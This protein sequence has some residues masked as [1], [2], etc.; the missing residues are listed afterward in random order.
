MSGRSAASV[1]GSVVL[2]TALCAATLTL[3]W[4]G[5]R[6]TQDAKLSATLLVERRAAEQLALLWAGVA[7]D[8]K[9][10]HATVLTPVTPAQLALEPPYD[11]ADAFARGF[12]RFP[13]PESFFAWKDS[14]SGDGRT[15]AFTR[16]DRPPHWYSPTGEG[17]AYPVEV[18][19]DPEALRPIVA[20]ARHAALHQPPFAVFETVVAG[21]TYQVVVNFFYNIDNQ[22][23]LSGLVG[24]TA[25]LDWVREF[26]FDELLRQLARIGG[27]P[28]DISLEI[29]DEA[30]RLVASNYANSSPPSVA[31]GAASAQR[32][33]QL[34]F[35]DRSLMT[36]LP[37]DAFPA[38]MWTARARVI[39]G[40]PVAAS[41]I[42]SDGAFGLMAAAAV[43]LVVALLVTVRGI[44][45]AAELAGMKSDFVSSVTHELKTPLAGIRL[46]ADTLVRGR[47]DSVEK[48]RDY[49]KLLSRE[50]KNLTRLID[51][52]LAYSRI[53]DVRHAYAFDPVDVTDL[54]TDTLAIFEAVLVDQKF[55]VEVD[56]PPELPPVRADRSAVV[57]ALSNVVDNALKY[58]NGTKVVG[59]RASVA[60]RYVAVSVTDKG[61]GIPKAEIQRVCEKFYRGREATG[62]GSGLGLAI[63]RQIVDAH[64]GFLRIESATGQGTRVELA[65]PQAAR[66]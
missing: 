62:A 47:Y 35:F 36:F 15:Y 32:G 17:G 37:A 10:A 59:I 61:I 39:S 50:A 18:L 64:G 49:A 20:E 42:G 44:R 58:S 46:I 14:G 22:K 4:F 16:A 33:F 60:D 56:V 66:S 7:Q 53:S 34:V 31:D 19:R 13:Y 38:R 52:L 54:V 27:S 2:A 43:A 57:L 45:V 6:A 24:F 55:A 8:M 48:I 3:V 65:L 41:S 9:G 51:N 26:Y 29:V 63:V 25:D 23:D 12:A 5:Y 21:R 1:A 40:S 28:G 11:L 30:G